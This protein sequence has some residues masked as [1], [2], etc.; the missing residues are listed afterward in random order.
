MLE[1][2]SDRFDYASIDI[3]ENNDAF[4]ID[5]DCCV[6]VRFFVDLEVDV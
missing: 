5:E 3:K 4:D 6:N 2:M 1:H